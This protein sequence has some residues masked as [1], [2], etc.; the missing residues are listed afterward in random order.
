MRSQNELPRDFHKFPSQIIHFLGIPVFFVFFV[1]L[2]RPEGTVSFLDMNRDIMEFN[3]IMVGC[4]LLGVL[5][6][7][8]L[9]FSF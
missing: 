7:T 1:L 8:R 5:V 9:A 6:A 4:I 3:L 2:Y